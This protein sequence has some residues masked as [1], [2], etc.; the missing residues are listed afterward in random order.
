VA[1]AALA[2]ARD[3][4]GNPADLA[5]LIQT[6]VG[7]TAR[8]L[9]LANSPA[10]GRR[11][12]T[13][14]VH[15]AVVTVGM[16]TACNILVAICARQL[17]V[18]PGRY[19]EVLWHHSLA[20]AVAAEDLA[21]VTRRV[22]PGAAFLPGLLH[23]IGRI[24]FLLLDPRLF[25]MI[26]ELVESGKGEATAL[27]RDCYDLDHAQVGGVLA[28]EWGLAPEQCDAIQWHHEPARGG[29][30]QAL[31]TVINAADH[32][33]YTIGYGSS[34]QVPPSVS[35]A[36]LGLSPDDEVACADRARE[37]FELQERLIS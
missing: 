21:R 25:E 28:E 32:L 8:I 35:M 12:E 24:A 37:A 33:A 1:T 9:R 14:S 34:E 11:R 3:P 23:D 4:D 27:E 31:A 6:D 5:R 18:V 15:D 29:A 10:Y 30:G 7:L 20:V 19:T 2:I 36:I 16:R 17:Y 13:Q 26:R 22:R